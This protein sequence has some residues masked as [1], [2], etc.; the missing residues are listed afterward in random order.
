MLLVL[1]SAEVVLRVD[2]TSLPLSSDSTPSSSDAIFILTPSSGMEAT[3]ASENVL[4]IRLKLGLNEFEPVL[5]LRFRS[6]GGALLMEVAWSL[7]AFINRDDDVRATFPV[8]VFALSGLMSS[9]FFLRALSFKD[10]SSSMS[11]FKVHSS[12]DTYT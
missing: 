1:E 10:G 3:S 9:S 2:M 12:N 4:P 6:S 7:A 8:G 11:L 5:S